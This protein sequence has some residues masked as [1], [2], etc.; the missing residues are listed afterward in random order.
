MDTR[1]AAASVSLLAVLL[2]GCA[3]APAEEEAPPSSAPAESAPT[4]T[5]APEETA[6][7]VAEVSL[8]GIS[9]GDDAAGF[10]DG[11]GALA[12]LGDAL[13]STPEGEQYEGYPITSYD[14]G[15]LSLTVT[16]TSADDA[17]AS[18]GVT[19]ADA[20][21]IEFRTAEGGISVG[22]TREE[23]LAAG[24]EPGGYDGDDDGRPEY[25]MLEAQEA[26]GTQSLERT[27]EAGREFVMLTV[28]DDVVT[29]IQAPSNDFSDL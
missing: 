24:A 25:L 13:G 14:W 28:E 26:P 29:G 15:G 9:F 17:R 5:P 18:I 23:A 12:L 21:G 7:A 22:A 8:D 10:D 19:A 27:G 6:P 4:E 11:A 20:D 1:T 2:A 16:R 3:S